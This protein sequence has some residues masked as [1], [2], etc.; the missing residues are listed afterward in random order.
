M[1]VPNVVEVQVEK[2]IIVPVKTTK[3]S[4]NELINTFERDI[5]VDTNVTIPVEGKEFVETD[6]EVTDEDLNRRIEQNRN[7]TNAIL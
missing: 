4:P 5:L 1:L 6:I 7:N 3:T 2:E